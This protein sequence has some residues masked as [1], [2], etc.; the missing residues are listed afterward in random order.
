MDN[1]FSSSYL[2]SSG[3]WPKVPQSLASPCSWIWNRFSFLGQIIHVSFQTDQASLCGI[4]IVLMS[5][6]PEGVEVFD[7]VL[8]VFSNSFCLPFFR[9]LNL[10]SP[11][12]SFLPLVDL[13]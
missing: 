13:A 12:I 3:I 11:M 9:S 7:V 10:S 6:A 5:L 4:A 2:V 8:G 1:S